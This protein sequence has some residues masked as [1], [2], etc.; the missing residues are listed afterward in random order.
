[1]NDICVFSF[2]FSSAQ[3]GQTA[4][5]MYGFK[6]KVILRHDGLNTWFSPAIIRSGCNIDITFFPFDD[7]IC[8]LKFGSW[9]Y[10]GFD[11]NLWNNSG[12]ADLKPYLQSAEFLLI[13]TVA[14]RVE[15]KYRYVVLFSKYNE[16]E[17]S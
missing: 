13:E 15:F 4:G 14:K 6:T 17:C 2:P 1:M 10:N 8:E 5:T 12:E 9:T 7:Q 11:V 16:G 3:K